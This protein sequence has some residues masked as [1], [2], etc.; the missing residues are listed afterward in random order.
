[1]V[2]IGTMTKWICTFSFSIEKVEYYLYTY[3]YSYSYSINAKKFLQNKTSSENTHKQI[4][5][6]FIYVDMSISS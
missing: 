4:Y 3:P 2:G 5:L 6:S 1:M